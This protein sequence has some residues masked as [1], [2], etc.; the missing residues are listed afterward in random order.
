[1]TEAFV[2]PELVR[3]ITA[4]YAA[5]GYTPAEP[6]RVPVE[7][8]ADGGADLVF[9]RGDQLVLVQLKRSN[10]NVPLDKSADLTRLARHV[11]Q[12]PNIRL[13][14]INVPDPTDVLPDP[15]VI[16]SRAEAA[17]GMASGATDPRVLEAA[18]LLAASAAEG[19]LIRLLRDRHVLVRPGGFA[20][21]AATAWSEGLMTQ[22]QWDRLQQS[23]DRRNAIAHGLTPGAAVVHSDVES[24]V[25]LARVFA[26]PNFQSAL[27]LV[28]WFFEL[29][30][31]PAQ[32][33]PFDSREGGY[34][35]INGGPYDAED[36]LMEQFPNVSEAV[37]AL[38]V[39]QIE[40]YGA[41]WVRVEDY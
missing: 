8:A 41:E 32:G 18:L 11:Q 25:E 1:M 5:D 16:V 37:R 2:S 4:R 12:L 6:S 14:V 38:A 21:L 24:L 7:L 35:Y 28:T 27:D 20:T 9:E 17:A 10:R 34:Q 3:D 29:Y 31:D 39:E 26:D 33:V 30:Q 23:I 13:D 22:A 19:A 36:V 40:G 15:Q